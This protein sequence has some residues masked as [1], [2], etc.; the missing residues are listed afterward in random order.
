[1]RRWFLSY[2]S[3]DLAL[4]EALEAALRRKDAD[5]HIFFAPKSLRA[6]GAWLPEIAKEIAE[7]TAFVLLIGEKGVGDYQVREYYEAFD[8]N[9]KDQ[10]FRVIL[11]LLDGHPAPGLPFLRQLHWIVTADPASEQSVAKLIDAVGGSGSRPNALWRHTAPYRGLPAMTESDSDFFFGRGSETV[12]VI[13]T[14]EAHPDKLPILLGNS[15]VGKSSLAQA[16]IMAALARQGW[17]EEAADA[18]AWPAAFAHS[19][20]W[21]F[22]T[23]RPGTEPVKALVE[24]F[25]DTWQFEAGDPARIKRRNQWVELLLDAGGKITLSDL[26][27]ETERRDKELNRPKATAFFL[28]V[29]QGEELYVRAEPRQRARFSQLLAHGLGD[30]RLRALMS[31]RSD[32]LGALQGDQPLFDARRQIDVVPL[33]EAQLREVVSRPAAQLAARFET[34]A[35]AADIARRAADESAKDAG[36]LPL[37][38]YLLDDMWAQMVARGDGTLRL[39]AAAIELGGVLAQRADAFMA[40]RPQSEDALQRLLT[41]RLATVR[42]D[43]EP[44]RRRAARS[45]FTDEEWR[46]ASELADHPNRLLVTATTEGGETYA[47]V[48]HEA[49]FRRWEKLREWIGA[50]REFLVWRSGLEAARRAWQATPDEAR[51]DAL[52]MGLSLAQAQGWAAKRADDLPPGDRDFIAA[53][54]RHDA[55]ERAQ[56]EGM[57]RR[58]WQLGAL[59]A[60]L[61]LGIGA[62]LAWS[63]RA[64]L[65][66]L[67]VT[68]AEMVWPR[69]L[70][71][72]AE[73]TLPPG[74]RF[75]ECADCP[76]MVVV[77]A[78]T[79]IMGSPKDEKGHEISEESQHKVSIRRFAVSRT[80]V[81]FE[82]WDACHTLGG[83]DYSPSDQGWGRDDRPVI[84]VSWDDAQQFVAWLSRRTGRT[85]RLLAE[86]EW[87]YAARAGSQTAFFWGRE[88]EKDGEAMANCNGC[89]SQWDFKQTAPVGQFPPSA[90]GL[91]DMHGNVWEW[92]Q[93]CVHGNYNGAPRDGAA[94]IEGG[95]C[96]R[97][98]VR[99]GAWNVE[100]LN[101][102]AAN[103]TGGST[104]VRNNGLG[105]RVGRTLTP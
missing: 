6:G 67:S 7:A 87:E 91:H 11:A 16:G 58:A 77:P 1:M 50:E 93:D 20:H 101:V 85:Y 100:A 57:R 22:L 59:V 60:V 19:R 86:A 88:I 99:G 105:F 27:D 65:R 23:M 4:M 49:I 52:L 28:Y 70:S 46:L 39:P 82:Q 92:T 61:V 15:G 78:G 33:R 13:R 9:V 36:A 8:R 35:L 102:R 37:L 5:A 84:N 75:V 80:E 41:L 104:V 79:F 25:F 24:A 45:E 89:G 97:R 73:R 48:A 30:P 43:G 94:W 69:V 21:C 34:E 76:E 44:T 51:N 17:P 26:L 14:L 74:Q 63:S 90:F 68:W 3:Q 72:E 95:D 96:D 54:V 103:R 12:A 10:R 56:R 55:A 47:E 40:S 83:C 62:G 31:L 38:S 71:V 81:T 29:D 42:E 66:A 2:N 64:Y 53:S 32:F 98:V 18:G